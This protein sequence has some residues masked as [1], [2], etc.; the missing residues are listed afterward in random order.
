MSKEFFL[1][2]STPPAAMAEEDLSIKHSPTIS[3][4][5]PPRLRAKHVPTEQH[6]HF[7]L[8]PDFTK[9]QRRR[10][11]EREQP[12]SLLTPPLTPSSSIRTTTSLDS[13]ASHREKLNIDKDNADTF[14]EIRDPDA[15][16]T[17]FLLVSALPFSRFRFTSLKSFLT[18]IF[19]I[20]E[21]LL[22][23]NFQ[24]GNVNDQVSPDV[25]KSA[26]VSSLSASLVNSPNAHVSRSY[27]PEDGPVKG[28][29][30]RFQKSK[31]IVPFIFNDIRLARAAKECLS[32][33]RKGPLEECI[34]NEV[35]EDGI[36]WITTQFLTAEEL[37]S[38]CLCHDSPIDV[39]P[40]RVACSL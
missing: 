34:G 19:D 29:N 9:P 6:A 4:I 38:V 15:K 3:S 37:T 22:T 14:N 8:G 17:R 27:R 35:R 30:H 21:P 26:V 28:V 7:A 20:F 36:C 13:S 16:S 31:G 32:V 23:T 11:R 2:P 10:R 25:L 39:I 24:L 33:P 12:T 1:R 40:Q 5:Q 18:I